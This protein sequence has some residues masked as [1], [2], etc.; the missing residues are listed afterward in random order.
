[1]KELLDYCQILLAVINKEGW[2]FLIKTRGFSGLLAANA[3]SGWIGD[4]DEEEAISEIREHFLN[5]GYD[6]HGDWFGEYDQGTEV[7]S[8][9]SRS[10][11]LQGDGRPFEEST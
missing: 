2:R 9:Q 6:P 7:F 4:I 5:S 10:G 3:E 11:R 1:M 8:S